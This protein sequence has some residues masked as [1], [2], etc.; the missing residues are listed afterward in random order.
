MSCSNK[1]IFVVDG[2]IGT[3]WNDDSTVSRNPDH[4]RCSSALICGNISALF[5]FMAELELLGRREIISDRL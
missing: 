1:G 3:S 4:N 5:E 2:P